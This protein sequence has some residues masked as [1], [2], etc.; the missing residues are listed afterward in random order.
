M[1]IAFFLAVAVLLSGCIPRRAY[2]MRIELREEEKREISQL[3]SQ[4]ASRIDCRFPVGDDAWHPAMRKYL[5]R[6]C[7]PTEPSNTDV[8]FEI[9]RDGL[10]FTATVHDIV[11]TGPV[12]PT[13]QAYAE[14]THRVLGELFG[15]ERIT[16]KKSNWPL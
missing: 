13:V 12:R 9:Q 5:Y 7:H 8:V 2:S 14:E 15:N 3:V 10:R 1:A 16:V 6:W 4:L 11:P